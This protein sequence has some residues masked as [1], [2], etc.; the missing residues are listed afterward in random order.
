MD[1]PVGQ[2]RVSADFRG[3]E[4]LDCDVVVVG[5]GAGGAAVAWALSAAGLRVLIL[6]EGRKF[7]PEELTPKPSWAFRNLY[8]ERS[9]RFMTGSLIIPLAGGRAVGGST[10][11]NSAICFRTPDHVLGRWR[12][13]GIS[14]ADPVALAPVF[15][16]VER[17][18]GVEK[19]HP[20][21]ARGN[22][23]IFKAGAEA[24]GMRG[25][26]ISRNA[27]GAWAAGCASWAVPS[28]ARE[29]WTATSSPARWPTARG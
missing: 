15:Q 26:F 23:L 10:L 19:T 4:A 5:S 20:S 24:L 22:N 6:E 21:Q 18:I 13:L 16:E 29:A 1:F 12:E 25:D 9:A 11:L 3:N 27:P 14:W 28:G 8:A 17:E 2:V 7:E